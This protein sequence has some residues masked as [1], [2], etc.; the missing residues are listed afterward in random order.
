ML[1]RFFLALTLLVGVAAPAQAAISLGIACS[2]LTNATSPAAM[3]CT[4]LT[5][6]SA[7]IL[8]IT[9]S[10]GLGDLNPFTVTD[11]TSGAWVEDVAPPPEH[12]W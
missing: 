9:A 10:S 1:L 2:F 11:D 5:A 3:T 7:I 8:L 4:G 12:R 6:N